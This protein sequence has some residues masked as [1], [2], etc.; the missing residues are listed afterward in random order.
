MEDELTSSYSSKAL[1]GAALK[2]HADDMGILT[3]IRDI[4]S[5]VN[6]NIETK[7]S[8]VDAKHQ[9][10]PALLYLKAYRDRH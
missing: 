6:V 5:T 7:T 9:V 2:L 3:L 1:C 4:N 10:H 8:S